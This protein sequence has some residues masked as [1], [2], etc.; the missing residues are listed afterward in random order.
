MNNLNFIFIFLF[1]I[2]FI[3]N[4]NAKKYYDKK[5]IK[6]ETHWKEVNIREN[7]PN[8][9]SLIS[10]GKFDDKLVGKYDKNYYYPASAGKDIDIFVFDGGFEFDNEDFTAKDKRISK[11]VIYIENGNITKSENEKVCHGYV[12]TFHGKLTSIT[13]AGNVYGVANKA[14]VYGIVIKYDDYDEEEYPMFYNDIIAGLKY[15]R[16]HLFR[17]HKAVFN[18][19]FGHTFNST[20]YEEKR[21]VLEELQTIITEMSNEGAVFVAAAGNESTDTAEFKKNNFHNV[22][23]GLDNVISVGGIQNNIKTEMI[24]IPNDGYYDDTMKT[25]RYIVDQRSNYGEEVDIYAPFWMHYRGDIYFEEIVY[26]YVSSILGVDISQVCKVT[27]MDKGYLTEDI[28]FIISGTSFSSPIVAGVAATIMSENPHIKFTTKTMLEYLIR[29]GE[30]NII[31]GIPEG[32]PNVFIN[33]GKHTVYSRNNK[34]YGCGLRA[35]NKKC[36]LGQYCTPEGQCSRNKHLCNTTTTTTTTT[37]NNNNK[38]N[39]NN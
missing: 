21:E 18:F 11:C 15:V 33:N 16:K 20:Q 5:F 12:D 19:S 26:Q 34:Y 38:H 30:K 3:N 37:N 4:V 22:P 27:P 9:L 10:Q 13:A 24:V 8:H 1:V 39:N 14:N 36:G 25:E 23:A 29:I 28:E 32:A 31:D 6:S 2:S 35:G 17:P 7:A